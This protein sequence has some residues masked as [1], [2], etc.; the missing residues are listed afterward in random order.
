MSTHARSSI[1]WYFSYYL[2]IAVLSKEE[3]KQQQKKQLKQ[4]KM[5]YGLKV[6]NLLTTYAGFKLG[7]DSREKWFLS[8]G[9]LGRS[10]SQIGRSYIAKL[11]HFLSV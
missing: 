6:R 7:P 9:K 2:E 5:K 11:L 8:P 1:Y 3:K 4:I 10:D